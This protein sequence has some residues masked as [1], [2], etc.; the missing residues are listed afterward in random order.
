MS[1]TRHLSAPGATRQALERLGD[2]ANV[3]LRGDIT[4]G[5]LP[6]LIKTVPNRSR[7][8]RLNCRMNSSALFAG[9]PGVTGP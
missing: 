1:Y 6:C 5:G 9:M 3:K 4:Q 2:L 7:K 8:A